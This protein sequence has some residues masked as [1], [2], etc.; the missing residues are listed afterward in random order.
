MSAWDTAGFRCFVAPKQHIPPPYFGALRLHHTNAPISCIRLSASPSL[1][2][3]LR[4]KVVAL[5]D[6]RAEQLQVVEV[7]AATLLQ[8]HAVINLMVCPYCPTCGTGELVT[9]LD[10]APCG[11]PCITTDAGCRPCLGLQ[12]GQTGG[13]DGGQPVRDALQLHAQACTHQ[14]TPSITQA[15]NGGMNSALAMAIPKPS[16]LFSTLWRRRV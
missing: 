8:W 1:G 14:P 9:L 16:S 7:V 15:T 3:L 11:H 6:P 2:F 13:G 12:H 4:L 10:L 5:S